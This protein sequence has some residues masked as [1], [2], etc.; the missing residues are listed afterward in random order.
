MTMR[1]PLAS[2]VLVYVVLFAS[3]SNALSYLRANGQTETYT[4][5][6]QVFGGQSS[7]VE[8]PDCNHTSFGPHITQVHDPT[9]D[10]FVFAFHSHIR[11]D[12]DR[13]VKFDRQR[14]EIKTND[15]LPSDEL[16]GHLGDHLTLSWDFKLDS[17]FQPPYSFCHIHQLK[18]VGGDDSMP[19]ITLTPRRS[20]PAN[21]IQLIHMD[22]FGAFRILELEPLEPWLGQWVHVVSN[23]TLGNEGRYT[24]EATRKSDGAPLM[25]FQSND[26]DMWRNATD[27]IRPKWGIYRSVQEA[28]VSR[29]EVVLFH[30]F[31]V[32]KGYDSIC[33]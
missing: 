23:V 18:A 24:F 15:D 4:L 12:D 1:A 5:I 16:T 31:C 20:H 17:E 11:Q 30:D 32:S 13:C 21:V 29:D 19:I 6:Q 22:S 27:F 8:V 7:A 28:V 33:P 3:T 2:F 14:T 9:L 10:S 26:I 25:S